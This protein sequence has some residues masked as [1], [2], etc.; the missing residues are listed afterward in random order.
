MSRLDILCAG[1]I[2]ADLIFTGV[3]GEV[4][5]GREV[6][7]DG[8][9]VAA[10]G[11]A[12]ITACRAAGQGLSAG[13]LG[14]A[15]VPPF[16][17][18]ARAAL[19]DHGVVDHLAA[20]APGS[21]PQLTVVVVQG[22]ERAFLTRRPGPALPVPIRLPAARHLHIGELA[23]ALEHRDLIPLAR[24]AGMSVSLD[25]GWDEAAFTT[26]G[27]AEIVAS[28]DVFLPNAAEA[29]R[30]AAQDIPLRPR[31]CLVTKRGAAGA[32]ASGPAG[33]AEAPSRPVEVIDTTGAGDAFNAG[34]LAGWL[35]GRPLADSLVAGNAAGADA[36]GRIG[37]VGS[38]RSETIGAGRA[39][40]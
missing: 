21:E 24:A 34:F 29:E 5:Q 35:G 18:V 7:A 33:R 32:T 37:G 39:V 2:Y 25:C 4:Q 27:I 15:P 22:T 26:S 20:A 38:P 31:H 11:G 6:F 12:L 9:A 10:G 23:T 28:V 8:L 30:L 40:S 1:R 19:G 36:V 13:V 17:R 16:D 14:I 3:A